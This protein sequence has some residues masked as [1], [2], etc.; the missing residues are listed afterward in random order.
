M[1][2]AYRSWVVWAVGLSAYIVAVLHRTSFGVAGLE[3]GERYDATP[4]VLAG[5][6]VL[7]L[8]V[9][10]ALQVPGGLALDRFGSRRM[11]VAGGLLMAGGQFVLAVALG[12]PLAVFGRVMVGAGDA[13]TFISVLRLVGRWFPPRR[14]PLMT[15][16]TGLVGQLGQVLSAVPLLA[17]LYGVGWTAAFGS[18]AALGVLVVVLTLLVVR[19]APPGV[20]T[21]PPPGESRS[22]LHGLRTSWL[23]RGTRLGV[24]THAGTQFSSTVFALLWGAPFLIAAQGLSPAEAGG[25]LALLVLV[26][27]VFGPLFGEFV[28]RYPLRRS[29]LV[30]TVIGLTAAT[31]TVVLVLPQ[32][33]PRWLLVV[34]VVVL[35]M[36]APG[37]MIG[38]DYARTFNPEH[39]QGSAVGMVN[40]GGFLAAPL[41]ALAMGIVLDLAGGYTT[42]AFRLAWSVQYVGWV[43]AGLAVWISRERIRRDLAADGQVITPIREVLARHRRRGRR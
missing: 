21:D 25:L 41:V 24:W 43:A 1:T 10:A 26:G 35:A 14:V 9:Y 2:G 8:L 34:L 32:P 6:V 33:V 20:S 18:A 4:A 17:V 15:Q 19:D 31:W 11:L 29:T 42:D 38:F 36:G 7:Q 12:L 23:E 5:F 3:A 28:A 40:M 37:S 39:R 30:L 27:I 13:V 22:L 16:M